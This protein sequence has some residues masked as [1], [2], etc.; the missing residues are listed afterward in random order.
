MKKI[1]I[2]LFALTMSISALADNKYGIG[3]GVGVSD[4]IYKGANDKAYPIP[5]FDINY[6]NLYVKGATVGYDVYKND[7]F[8]A[9]LFI[10]P[11][12]GFAVKGSDLGN[13]YDHIDDRKFQAMFGLRLD[14]KTPFYGIRTGAL[15]QF[16]NHGAE[17]K[18]SVFKPYK[19]YD[20]FILVP[21][22]HIRGY[23]GN[24]TDYY[25]GVT[26]SEANDNRNLKNREYDA[27][28]AYSVGIN[29]TADYKLND[30]LAFVAF[31]G[32]ERF[33]SEISDSPIVEDSVLY[34]VGVG[35][36]YYF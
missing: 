28:T 20:N 21:S 23:S 16:G 2:G 5:L 35:A 31:L 12:A 14:Y 8:A 33:S 19:V 30:D 1:I 11:L 17:G 29:L 22:A 24:Y 9:S 3:I 36:K 18:L 32:V 27:D 34:L 6:G 26:N 15:T 10:D 25:F 4:S 7:M 13:G